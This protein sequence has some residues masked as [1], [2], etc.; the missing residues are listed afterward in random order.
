MV[1]ETEETLIRRISVLL[2]LATELESLA[3]LLLSS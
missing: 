2:L 1:K 3:W